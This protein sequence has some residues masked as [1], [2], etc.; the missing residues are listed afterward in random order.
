MRAFLICSS[1]TLGTVTTG[2]LEHN[3]KKEADILL[4]FLKCPTLWATKIHSAYVLKHAYK[5]LTGRHLI[6]LK[7]LACQL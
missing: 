3:A 7:S 5:G 6:K 2:T 1:R 4:P